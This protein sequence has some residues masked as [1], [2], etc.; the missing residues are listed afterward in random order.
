VRQECAKCALFPRATRLATRLVRCHGD[1]I[2][3]M[4]L[5]YCAAYAQ[6]RRWQRPPEDKTVTRR[7]FLAGVGAVPVVGFNPSSRT[8]LGLA[9]AASPFDHVRVST[10][11]C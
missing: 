1:A 2:D 10:E 7:H 3:A 11:S 5:E 9:E 8:W 4:R 6:A